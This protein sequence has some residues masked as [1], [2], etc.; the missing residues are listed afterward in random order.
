MFEDSVKKNQMK[1]DEEKKRQ[2]LYEQNRANMRE[3]MRKIKEL[4]KKKEE[5][6]SNEEFFEENKKIF[7]QLELKNYSELENFM[8][9][10][11]K[12]NPEEAEKE[13]KEKYKKNLS[14]EHIK[15]NDLNFIPE[16]KK[17][18]NLQIELNSENNNIHITKTENTFENLQKC[19]KE[20]EYNYIPDFKEYINN[21]TKIYEIKSLDREEF[22]NTKK[23]KYNNE[24]ELIESSNINNITYEKISKNKI[25]QE[26]NYTE[27]GLTIEELRKR[28]IKKMVDNMS[29]EDRNNYGKVEQIF[30]AIK[31]KDKNESILDEKFCINCN[32]SFKEEQSGGHAGHTI[33]QIDNYNKDIDNDLDNLDYNDCLNKL[34]ENLKKDQN[35]IL[36]KRKNKIIIYYDKIIFTLYEIITNNNSIEDLNLSIIKINEDFNNEKDKFNQYFK[37]YFLFYSQIIKKLAYLKEKK[38]EQLL[39]ELEEENN[40][41][42]TDTFEDE[43]NE[44]KNLDEQKTMN[45]E[46]TNSNEEIIYPKISENF[47]KIKINFDQFSEQDKKEY[48]LNLGL[49]MK[50]K[51][52]KKDSIASLYSR[53]KEQNIE[54]SDYESFLM[55]ELNIDNTQ[56]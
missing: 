7:E 42:E 5:S 24:N 37:D 10:Y 27:N 47:N 44:N 50:L 52:G 36:K 26:N 29:E 33:I 18:N 4:L 40:D 41:L 49:D 21:K 12:E 45:K 9:K 35:K 19:E 22:P 2:K 17:F 8:N 48:F 23:I 16:K 3:R 56:N 55:K 11:D 46:E 39:I 31:D 13:E 25:C 51:Y 54:P 14:I 32:L 20:K 43:D 38:M 53:A 28:K 6:K 30:N 15:N 1:K 34:Y